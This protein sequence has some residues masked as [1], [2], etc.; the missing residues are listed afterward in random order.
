[1][2]FALSNCAPIHNTY[3]Y[4]DI[5]ECGTGNDNCAEQAS[6]MNTDGSFMCTCHTGYNG[7]GVTCEGELLTCINIINTI[8]LVSF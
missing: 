7:N 5:D 8:I 6:C 3:I 2:K 1:M 4:T